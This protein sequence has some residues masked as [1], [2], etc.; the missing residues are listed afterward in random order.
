MINEVKSEDWILHLTTFPL[1]KAV[2]QVSQLCDASLSAV[3]IRPTTRCPLL[4]LPRKSPPRHLHSNGQ[5]KQVSW[6]QYE[7][8]T[9]AEDTQYHVNV[10]ICSTRLWG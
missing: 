8:G 7:L 6:F 9:L 10:L 5:S 4:N 3:I 1:V 2:P